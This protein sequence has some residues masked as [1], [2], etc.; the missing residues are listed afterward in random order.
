MDVHTLTTGFHRIAIAELKHYRRNPRR[1]NVKLIAES[2]AAHGQYRPIVVNLRTMEVIAGNHT[3]DGAVE[4]GWTDIDGWFVDVDDDEAAKIA[5]IDNRANDLA[6]YDDQALLDLLQSLPDLAATG[7]TDQD[8][9]EMLASRPTPGQTHPDAVPEA[10][11]PTSKTGDLWLLGP[12]RLLCGDSTKPGDVARV[13]AGERATLMV[14]DP[15]YAIG[16]DALNHPPTVSNG[17]IRGR[18]WDAYVDPA[19]LADDA[20]ATAFFAAFLK[21]ARAEALDRRAPIYQWTASRRIV[22]LAAAWKLNGL[23]LHAHIVWAKTRPVLGRSDFMM[24][25]ES[26]AA[27]ADAQIPPPIVMA[28]GFD[29]AAYGWHPGDR[30]PVERRPPA[31]ATTLWNIDSEYD[32]IHP[33]QKPVELYTRPIEWHTR[34]GELI[35]EPFGGSGTAVIAAHRTARRC[36]AIEKAPGF[37]DV[38]CRRYQEHTGIVPTREDGE[39]VDFTAPAAA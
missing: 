34:A 3:M 10:P 32:A 26:A 36:N 13:M 4:L 8:L 31:N 17:G 11:T 5:L 7:Y 30:P 15:P 37:V 38:I 12:H 28:D 35:F 1:G 9:A 33:T 6:G 39:P 16:Y 24:S 14:T 2:L 19:D 27:G 22:E 25:T 21:A 18:Q 29:Y 23:L 20:A